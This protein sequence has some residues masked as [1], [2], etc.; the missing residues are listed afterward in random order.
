M[1][2]FQLKIPKLFNKS[3][4]ITIVL[5]IDAVFFLLELITGFMV[6]SLALTADA[7]H[8]LNDIISLA[9]GLWAVNISKR[10]SSDRFSYG[11]VRAEVLGGFFN[12]VFLI[13][14]C[15]SIILESI[16]RF[17]EVPEINN[18]VLILIVG[19]CGLA[20]NI[21]GFFVL[22][23]GREEEEHDHDHADHSHGIANH[24]HGHEHEHIHDHDDPAA[25]EE[26]RAGLSSDAVAD[27]SGPAM[28]ALPQV[29]LARAG[30]VGGGGSSPET[31]RHIQISSPVRHDHLERS[32][33][34]SSASRGRERR[35]T[36]SLKHSRLQSIGDPSFH[37]SNFRQGIIENSR[38]TADD[39]TDESS[40]EES[41][42]A[43][44][45]RTPLIQKGSSVST[46]LEGHHTNGNNKG[47][48]TSRKARPRRDSLIHK[49][50]HH[51]KPKKAGKGGHSHSHGHGHSH[52][53][54]GMNAMILH[55][56]GDALGNI[57]VI[58]TALVI[59]LTD[60]PGKYYAD[61]AL[62]LFIT[63]IIL[64]TAL[65]LTKATAHVLLQGTPEEIDIQDIKED[66]Q[67]LK[68]VISCHHVHVWTL[69]NNKIVASL[70]IQVALPS[71]AEGSRQYMELAKQVRKCLHA[72]KI[73]S[74]T[75]QPEFCVDQTCDHEVESQLDGQITPTCSTVGASQCLLG[76]TDDCEAQKC[77][78]PA[79]PDMHD[80]DHDHEHEHDH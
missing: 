37:P 6:H 75:I 40:I 35:R 27:N 57:G 47:R 13:A 9:V 78:T 8:M 58:A 53:D 1:A 45:E 62:S 24:D 69:S 29:V 2:F 72:Y 64:K 15:I 16:T 52:G 60:W 55:V 51:N 20:S 76:C 14:L 4:S 74:A 67:A 79:K 80:H 71:T 17:I 38:S 12:A 32:G 26:G 28:D 56:I 5:V 36:D 19:C 70:H 11:W 63:A 42:T 22:E 33:S 10:K 54:M 49:D 66:I 43:V 41:D 77:C 7:F 31:V 59:W 18:P 21:L 23:A 73:H 44:N 65:P 30:I 48:S 68:G 61:P 3:T 34:Q 46:E 39:T 50:H 25:V